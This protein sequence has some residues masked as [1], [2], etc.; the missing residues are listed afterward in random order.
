MKKKQTLIA[1][2]FTII[3][4]TGLLVPVYADND[5]SD[6]QKKQQDINKQI[7]SAQ[8]KVNAEKQKESAIT[9]QI[10]KLEKN[11]KNTQS[12]INTLDARISSLNGNIKE[13]ED[14][15]KKI[16]EDM[17]EQKEILSERLVFI[18][19]QGDISYLEVLLSADDLKDFL[20]RYDMLQSIVNQDREMI[21]DLHEK[22]R[23]VVLQKNNLEIQ[24]RELE[25][26]RT[27]HNDEKQILLAQKD[28]KRKILNSVSRQRKQREQMVRD[29][30]NTSNELEQ[31]IRRI[32][33][34]GK[35]ELTG[36]GIYTWPTPGYKH[37]TCPFGQRIHPILKVRK[38]H[39]G[40]DI[41]APSGAKI[42]AADSGTVIRSTYN[43]AY[44]NVVVIDHGNGMS[45]LYAHQS[46][47]LVKDGDIVNKGDTIGKVGSTG[48]STGPHLHFE[49]RVNGTPVNPIGYVK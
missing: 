14:E 44:G 1:L 8:N 40:I 26:A 46:R 9:T 5:L 49:V 29:L 43:G 3:F 11:M 23:Q 39:T 22:N 10:N 21:E 6:Y 33:S 17:V 35:G 42:V 37:I 30:E 19:E 47:R 24:K 28:D 38:L 27:K 7:D 41:G 31:A 32:Q 18:Y 16:E 2:I 34:G 48:W 13:T 12:E 15:V 25:S 36:T 45:T 4:V 20:T